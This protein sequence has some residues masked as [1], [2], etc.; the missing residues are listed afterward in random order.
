MSV[1]VGISL[2]KPNKMSSENNWN[3]CRKVF[4]VEDPLDGTMKTEGLSMN[5]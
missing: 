2:L 4:G 5:A 3:M 1:K